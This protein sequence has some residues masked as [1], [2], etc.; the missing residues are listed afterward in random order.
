MD[1]KSGC[2][3]GGLPAALALGDVVP[4]GLGVPA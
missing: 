4:Q 2:G 1:T 3:A